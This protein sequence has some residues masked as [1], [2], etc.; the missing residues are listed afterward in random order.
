[1]H[2]REEGSEI[3]DATVMSREVVGACQFS[4]EPLG[5]TLFTCGGDHMHPNTPH[6]T[7]HDLQPPDEHRLYRLGRLWAAL[8]GGPSG[9]GK[10]TVHRL[11]AVYDHMYSVDT[12]Y[13]LCYVCP[14]YSR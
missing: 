3:M 7:L 10:S 12:E 4:Q 13:P 8:Q 6:H 11:V 2:G 5:P 14:Q 1:M 9:Q